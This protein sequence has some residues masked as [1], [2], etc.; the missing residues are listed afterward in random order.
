MLCLKGLLLVCKPETMNRGSEDKKA[1]GQL[2]VTQQHHVNGSIPNKQPALIHYKISSIIESVFSFLS[3]P[4]PEL[5]TFLDWEILHI[6]LSPPIR[7]VEDWTSRPRKWTEVR[8]VS[9]VSETGCRVSSQYTLPETETHSQLY[10]PEYSEEEPRLI[11]EEKKPGAGEPNLFKRKHFMNINCSSY[12][13]WLNLEKLCWLWL[14]FRVVPAP[15]GKQCVWPWK[16]ANAV[17]SG[18]YV[19]LGLGGYKYFKKYKYSWNVCEIQCQVK[20][21]TDT[22]WLW[23]QRHSLELPWP[24]TLNPS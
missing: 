18:N 3:L 2:Q 9:Q 14:I 24:N 19:L 5:S 8:H 15:A 6:F 23:C 22:A 1:L 16:A 20:G 7:K 12:I 4:K 10:E 13:L 21:S 11:E 17:H